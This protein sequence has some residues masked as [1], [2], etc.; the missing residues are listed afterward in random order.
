MA[1]I[2]SWNGRLNMR[3]LATLTLLVSG[4]SFA[5]TQVPHTFS[6]GQPARASAVNENF[7][8]LETAIDDVVARLGELESQLGPMSNHSTSHAYLV[9][10]VSDMLTR[11]IT[12]TQPCS[13]TF[14]ESCASLSNGSVAL[15]LVA[16]SISGNFI[17]VADPAGENATVFGAPSLGTH[18]HDSFVWGRQANFTRVQFGAGSH[19]L[20]DSCD[21]PT[22]QLVKSGELATGGLGVDNGKTFVATDPVTGGYPET[23]LYQT[24]AT[25]KT[26]GRIVAWKFDQE[27]FD[28]PGKL[29]LTV[30]D[31]IGSY[32][33]YAL[34]LR[35]DTAAW[36]GTWTPSP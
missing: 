3:L 20:V 21:N 30:T 8:A 16:H 31:A 35:D 13:Q 18:A 34:A 28:N 22:V 6:S 33:A 17:V 24:D 4:I 23:P 11:L 36:T 27:S 12:A 25:G 19:V 10:N 32:D 29:C 15:D 9:G 2:I 7:N 5:E 1:R 26:W 14:L